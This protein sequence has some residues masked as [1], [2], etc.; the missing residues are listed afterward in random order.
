[1]GYPS[2]CGSKIKT[3]ASAI[4]HASVRVEDVESTTMPSQADAKFSRGGAV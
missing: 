2:A 1:M 3:S 4:V